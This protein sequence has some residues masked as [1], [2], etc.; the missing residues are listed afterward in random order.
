MQSLNEVVSNTM[1]SI[2]PLA[3]RM[4]SNSHPMKGIKTPFP[5]L[6]RSIITSCI[7]NRSRSCAL[8]SLL[9]SGTS[10]IISTAP[11]LPTVRTTSPSVFVAKPASQYAK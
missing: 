4:I 6:K 8:P 1:P 10:S 2:M 5:T 7:T 9:Y 3:M 11:S